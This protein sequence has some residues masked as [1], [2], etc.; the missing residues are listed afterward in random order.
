LH[1][2][3]PHLSLTITEVLR[4]PIIKA[5]QR[6][7]DPEQAMKAYGGVGIYLHSFL[8]T[9]LDGGKVEPFTLQPLYPQGN[10]FQ[11]PLNRRHQRKPECL[12]RLGLEPQFLG[13]PALSLVSI[14][15]PNPKAPKQGNRI[16]FR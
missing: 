6:K 5:G 7:A 11:I 3:H 13:H 12:N 16:I 1:V 8:T 9:S 10:L 14:L 2:E 4:R 15:I